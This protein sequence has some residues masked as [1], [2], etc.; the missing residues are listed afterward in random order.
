MTCQDPGDRKAGRSA[1]RE[2]PPG[3]GHHPVS[4]PGQGVGPAAAGRYPQAQAQA[5]SRSRENS[6]ALAAAAATATAAAA[7]AGAAGAGG[8]HPPAQVS[9]PTSLRCAPSL[10]RLFLL[11]DT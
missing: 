4:A 9:S 10:V 3:P 5:A 8:A 6:V 1:E 11:G 7:L 2:L